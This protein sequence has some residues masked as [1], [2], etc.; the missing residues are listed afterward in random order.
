MSMS[1]I[2]FNLNFIS[3]LILKHFFLSPISFKCTCFNVIFCG[4]CGLLL[5]DAYE[6]D[7]S[8]PHLFVRVSLWTPKGRVDRVKMLACSRVA[9]RTLDRSGKYC[10]WI[11]LYG[12]QPAKQESETHLRRFKQWHSEFIITTYPPAQSDNIPYNRRI[13]LCACCSKENYD[14][15]KQSFLTL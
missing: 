10:T 9:Q 4:A 5:I 13:N 6:Y 15:I 3:F 12:S 14:I 2:S 11:S 8:A 1:F 7:A